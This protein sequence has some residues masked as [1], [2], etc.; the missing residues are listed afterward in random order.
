MAA[1][2]QCCVPAIG[3]ETAQLCV[4]CGAATVAGVGVD[5]PTLLLFAAAAAGAAIGFRWVRARLTTMP[6][7]RI[8]RELAVK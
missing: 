2:S 6:S 4:D 1:C 5:V 7:V 8:R 3:S